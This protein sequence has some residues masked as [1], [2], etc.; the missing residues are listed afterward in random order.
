MKCLT[1]IFTLI[2]L[3]VLTQ[4]V[5]SQR[6]NLFRT[7]HF[8]ATPNGGVKELEDFVEQAIVY[9]DELLEEDIEGK[10]YITFMVDYRGKVIYKS[11]ADTGHVLLQKEAERIF[12]RIVWQADESR[13]T[14]S[15]G[16]EKIKFHF[17]TKKYKRLCKK[18]GYEEL[19][20]GDYDIDSSATV[21][22]INQVDKKPKVL[23]GESVNSFVSKNFRYPSLAYQQNISGR[24]TIDFIIEP[25]GLISNVRLIEAVPGGCN[26]E[27]IRLMRAIDWLPGFKAGKAV[28]TSFQYQLNFRHPG[29]TVR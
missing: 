22:S 20:Y 15:L 26:E 25:Y 27:T 28:R 7:V 17:D 24:V 6:I 18:R 21:Y 19:P 11:V 4:A 3:F 8:P 14:K 5:Q 12:D 1:H 13:N 2:L 23:N 10:I 9:P 29:G 16:Y